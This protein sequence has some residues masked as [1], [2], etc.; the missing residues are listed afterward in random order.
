MGLAA[1][2][3]MRL[4]QAEKEKEEKEKE[5]KVSTKKTSQKVGE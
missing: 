2:N 1:F 3:R 5:K 4:L